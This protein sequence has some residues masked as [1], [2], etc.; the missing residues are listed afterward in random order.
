MRIR[1]LSSDVCSCDL[2][3]LDFERVGSGW[4][5][6]T[7]REGRLVYIAP[8]VAARLDR[9]LAHL[10][11]HPFTDIIRKRVGRDE[12]EERTLGFSLSSRT[13]IAVTGIASGSGSAYSPSS[14]ASNSLRAIGA[15]VEP[16]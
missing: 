3:N 4:F 9:P 7:D 6:E 15:A 11:G 16:P 13:P 2:L 14:Q 1:Y 5:W 12:S 8:T 10:L